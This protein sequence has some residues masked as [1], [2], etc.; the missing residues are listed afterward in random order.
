MR[1]R[2]SLFAL[3]VCFALILCSLSL[4]SFASYLPFVASVKEEITDT[5]TTVSSD[6]TETETAEATT[7]IFTAE[8]EEEVFRREKETEPE[9]SSEEIAFSA[10]ETTSVTPKTEPEEETADSDKEELIPDERLLAGYAASN[11]AAAA[12]PAASDTDCALNADIKGS[13]ASAAS[14]NTYTFTVAERGV[15]QYYFTRAESNAV[16]KVA[17]Y[18]QYDSNGFDGEKQWRLLDQTETDPGKTSDVS[19]HI[20]LQKGV[21]RI[22]VSAGY[23]FSSAPY[24]LKASFEPGTDYEIECNDSVYR[25]TEISPDVPVRGSA[26]YLPDKNDKDY[27]MFRVYD[28]SRVNLTFSHTKADNLSVFWRVSLFD[29]HGKELY[30]D[31]AASAV[32]TIASGDI[33]LVPGVYFICVE[34]R[35]YTDFDYTLTVSRKADDSFETEPNGTPAEADFLPANG[36]VS[37]ALTSAS[38]D[39]DTDIFALT[40]EKPGYVILTFT[41][42]A[43]KD[44]ESSHRIALTD[45]AGKGVWESVVSPLE[46]TAVSPPIGLA[47]G[48][49]YVRVDDNGLFRNPGDYTVA[50][51]FTASDSWESEYN[52]DKTNADVIASGKTVTGTITDCEAEFDDDYYT[53]TLKKPA[54]VYV[55]L[56]HESSADE[57]NI[58]CVSL[59]DKDGK[60]VTVEDENRNKLSVN[61]INSFGNTQNAGGYYTLSS[62]TYYIRVTSGLFRPDM[63]YELTYSI[64]TGG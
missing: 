12:A 17:L 42:P 1:I 6:E 16:W 34:S 28:P 7:G 48:T 47:A 43:G 50:S 13:L 49:Y 44:E 35:V 31:N 18:Q 2:K 39:N 59:L 5:E 63:R 32:E 41:A 60:A 29:A 9:I 4:S 25:Y 30:A 11:G 15:L 56:A 62:G 46:N 37:G 20:G 54:F 53:F 64:K 58:F 57:K 38:G 26:G 55:T 52:G 8:K 3:I 51:V 61:K 14:V 45:A 27:F 24:T 33:G 19:P 10:K 36:T 40:A 22:V 23:S 21:Y